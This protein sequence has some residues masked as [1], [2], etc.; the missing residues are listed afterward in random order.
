MRGCREGKRAGLQS[1]EKIILEDLHKAIDVRCWFLPLF[2]TSGEFVFSYYCCK[3][4][5]INKYLRATFG[6][7][8][9]RGAKVAV[10][11]K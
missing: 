8:L 4:V 5:D 2:A 7:R 9:K 10:K 6:F 11:N 3:W 1:Y